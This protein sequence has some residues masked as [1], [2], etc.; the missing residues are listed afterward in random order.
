MTKSSKSLKNSQ[1][2]MEMIV[3]MT[4]MLVI[5]STGVHLLKTM[6][7]LKIPKEVLERLRKK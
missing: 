5:P 2:M 6:N 3:M 1:K 7:Q 4:K